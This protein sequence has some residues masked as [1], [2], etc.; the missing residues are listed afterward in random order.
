MQIED[1]VAWMLKRPSLYKGFHN[2][3]QPRTTPSCMPLE[4]QAQMMIQSYHAIFE[5]ETS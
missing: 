5:R 3:P 4:P 1:V 2:K